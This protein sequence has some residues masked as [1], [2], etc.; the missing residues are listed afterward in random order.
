MHSYADIISDDEFISLYDCYLSKT[1]DF[2][3]QPHNYFHLDNINSDCKAE[4]R[5]EKVD[6]PCLA[7]ALQIPAV[8]KFKQ[9]NVCDGIEELHLLLRRTSYPCRFSDIIPRFPKPVSVLS[10]TTNEV[11]DFIYEN[12]HHL[13]TEWNGN[14]PSPAAL[15]WFAESISR[16][17]SPL[18]NCFGFID[19]TVRPISRPGNGQRVVYNGHKRVHALTF[20]SVALPNGL[21]GNIFGPVGKHFL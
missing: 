21:I 11:L 4:F 18:N 8:F 2:G 17:G 16:K 13:V 10:L 12:H 19:G 15:Q 14:M 9:R 7:D 3:Y 6:L 5:V 1:P 20:Q